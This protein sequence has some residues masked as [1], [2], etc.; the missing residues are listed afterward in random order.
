MVYTE[1]SSHEILKRSFRN[2]RNV[3]EVIK[4]ARKEGVPVRGSVFF[5]GNFNSLDPLQMQ[6]GFIN[7]QSNRI[8]WQYSTLYHLTQTFQMQTY[9]S[10]AIMTMLWAGKELSFNSRYRQEFIFS[11]TFRYS[12]WPTQPPIHW[13]LGDLT[14]ARWSARLKSDCSYTLQH[15][16]PV[17]EN[18]T[19]L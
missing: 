9:G 11:K 3:G 17:Q 10:V 19:F 2:N 12:L 14:A 8:S 4:G 18:F 7:F 13:I 6:R 15:L 5:V 1:S 16:T